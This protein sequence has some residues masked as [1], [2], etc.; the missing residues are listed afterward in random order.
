MASTKGDAPSFS[1]FSLA[2]PPRDTRVNRNG[3]GR[4]TTA[5]SHATH[6]N[7]LGAIVKLAGSGSPSRRQIQISSAKKLPQPAGGSE[8]TTQAL[9]A[10]VLAVL[11]D[12]GQRP[13]R[14]LRESGIYAA[15]GIA[16]CTDCL[17]A[18][19]YRR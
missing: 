15:I 17:I 1:F 8:S 7:T 10:R 6:S 19:I 9:A 5:E 14:R 2:P 18:K 3:V 4:P 12:Q 13:R 11:I 16:A